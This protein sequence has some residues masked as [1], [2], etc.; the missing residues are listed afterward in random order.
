MDFSNYGSRVDLQG[1]GE[2]VTTTGYGTY[3][4]EWPD[5]NWDYTNSFAGTSSAAPNVAAAV[6]IVESI[7]QYNDPIGIAT[8]FGVDTV[9]NLLINTGLYQQS[10]THPASEHIGPRPDVYA[11]IMNFAPDDTCTYYKPSY[12]DYV[13]S[14]V[15]DF[16]QVQNNWKLPDGRWTHD[17]PVALANCLWW[18]DSKYETGSTPPPAIV[19]N[20]PLVQA[21][22]AGIDDHDTANVKPLVDTLSRNNYCAT[23]GVGIGGFGTSAGNMEAG[24]NNWLVDRGL[25]DSFTVR[26]IQMSAW[27]SIVTVRDE[28]LNDQNVILLL[29]FWQYGSDGVWT[30]IGGHYVTLAG[31]CAMR[32]SFCLSDPYF[33]MVEGEPYYFSVS[34]GSHA[35]D[36][37]NDAYYV[38]GPHKTYYHDRYDVNF[39]YDPQIPF[40]V[41]MLGYP[42]DYPD[43]LNFIDLNPGLPYV[44]SLSYLGREI[45]TLVE[46]AI[47]VCPVG[48]SSNCCIGLVG[49]VD[50]SPLEE[51]DISD[52][53]RLIDYLYISHNPLC[54]LKEADADVSGGEPDISDITRLIDY[55]Y[56]SHAPL[57]PCP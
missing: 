19:D 26:S 4:N 9:R 53:T 8:P 38:S 3:Y 51:P 39:F 35:A 14:G 33:D 12:T 57:L 7:F 28:V 42:I 55:L 2:A 46:R 13:P 31:V 15:P 34:T 17:G 54:C 22:K 44:P 5:S 52:I 23:N 40:M 11:A 16:D 10:G 47:I 45:K 32:A 6:A 36:F 43:I 30:R 41:E 18:F 1:W 48:S 29:G 56:I 49:N 50:C 27:D 37:H 20:Y 24:I 21:L 25:D